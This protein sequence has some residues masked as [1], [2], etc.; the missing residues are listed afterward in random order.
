[1]SQS[2]TLPPLFIGL[3]H[4]ARLVVAPLHTVPEID[5]T[6]PGFRDMPPVLAT[7]VMI[8]FIEET[9][10]RALRPFLSVRQR[11]L[12]RHLLEAGDL[13]GDVARAGPLHHQA[14]IFA[15]K[16]IATDKLGRTAPPNGP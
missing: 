16:R 7:A 15:A 2:D 1:M 13:V 14:G 4:V 3:R 11:I 10:V 9:C 5:D 8:A 12:H 6:W